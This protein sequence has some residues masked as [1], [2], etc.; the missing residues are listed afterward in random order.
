VAIKVAKVGAWATEDDRRRFVR[1]AR[2]VA[3]LRHPHIVPV[4][5]FGEIGESDYIAYQYVRGTTLRNLL[6]KERKLSPAKA[7][8]LIAKIAHALDYAHSK[9]IVHRDVKPENILIDEEGEP[10]VAD[11]GCARREDAGGLL[12]VEGQVMG[13]P[14]YMSPE[15]AAGQSHQADG[16][17]DVWSLGVMLQEMLTGQR[18]FQ[19]TLTEILVGIRDHD[20]KSIRV[21]DAELPRD[22][23]TICH[24]C[25]AKKPQERFQTA[26]VLADEIQRWL[27]GEPIHSRR[28]N[29]F[30]RT[31]RWAKRNRAV[32]SLL[33]AVVLTL[34]LGATI[35]TA[36]LVRALR[37]ERQRVNGLADKLWR[38][39]PAQVTSILKDIAGEKRT[40]LI[41]QRLLEHWKEVRAGL[42]SGPRGTSTV[43]D[44]DP[45]ATRSALGLLDVGFANGIREE[46]RKYLRRSLLQAPADQFW[47]IGDCL[48]RHDPELA[49]DLWTIALDA[50]SSKEHRL[51]SAVGL[52]AIDP[53]SAEW[54][55]LEAVLADQL[56]QDSDPSWLQIVWPIRQRLQPHLE[57]LFRDGDDSRK[58]AAAVAVRTLYREDLD[59]LFGLLSSADPIQCR[60][61]MLAIEQHGIDARTGLRRLLQKAPAQDAASNSESA[62]DQ[63]VVNYSVGL[64]IL[65]D[66]A[67]LRGMLRASADTTNRSS[68]IEQLG[69]SG[70]DAGRII[71]K[72]Q[73]L[74]ASDP[75]DLDA[76]RELSGWILALGQFGSNE[77]ALPQL[78]MLT[79]LARSIRDLHP[80]AGVHGAA[81]WL[82]RKWVRQQMRDNFLLEV[83]PE[84]AGS[85]TPRA[86]RLQWRRLADSTT[87][88]KLGPVP[89]FTLGSSEEER[90]LFYPYDLEE[91]EKSERQRD[92]QIPRKFEIASCE[93]TLARFIEFANDRIKLLEE[94]VR[95]AET[96]RN[97]NSPVNWKGVLDYWQ[98][99]RVKLSNSGN[100]DVIAELPVRDITW[101][102]A[103]SYCRWL[104]EKEGIPEEE[105]CYPTVEAMAAGSKN[106]DFP[107]L[108][109]DLL[110]RTGYRLPTSAE[111][112]WAC[113]AGTTKPWHWGR[114]SDMSIAYGWSQLDARQQ[115]HGI[116]LRKPNP[117]GL[118]DMHGN[119]AEWC[120]TASGEFAKG[121]LLVDGQNDLVENRYANA[122]VRGGSYEDGVRELRS[123]RRTGQSYTT[124]TAYLGFRIARTV[125][126][127]GDDS[128]GL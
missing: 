3:Q 127:N 84:S 5:E 53:E 21:Y 124:S 87:M 71:A 120:Q 51:R 26:G 81:E 125:K 123:A 107:G 61:L 30:D 6:S 60:Q 117:F 113:R 42:G 114:S 76:C 41:G 1:E 10:H 90:N 9:H 110:D 13:T 52:A 119:V 47:S 100:G 85:S 103:A 68:V 78:E 86:R 102:D 92:Y 29:V 50:G 55:K 18:P 72:V 88:I 49:D 15:Q 97:N 106:Y 109:K 27:R 2:A 104:S 75:I 73:E 23:E 28:I 62:S 43:S 95:L 45:M 66:E 38:A 40:D 91:I 25:L 56:L 94:K 83:S 99:Q 63:P 33:A 112:E 17:S 4:Y 74:N 118:F 34:A 57:R 11:F 98:R 70:M 65:G 19:G 111:W 121:D 44:F 93:V 59:V 64:F 22:L 108:P 89:R 48:R 16:R 37:E 20:A 67:P 96:A 79:P 39:D 32:A 12:T 116:G 8:S 80:D 77:L 115:P 101:W 46:L 54:E 122:V 36:F 31:W 69:P 35:S 126:S 58:Y 82:L 7:S 14:A 105:M 24:K 128:T